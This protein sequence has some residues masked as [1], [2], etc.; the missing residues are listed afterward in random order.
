MVHLRLSA[1]PIYIYIYISS[2]LRQTPPP[3]LRSSAVV[4]PCSVVP[5]L[6]VRQEWWNKTAPKQHPEHP[7]NPNVVPQPL[8]REEWWNKTAPKQRPEGPWGALELFW[9]PF[10]ST[11]P[12]LREVVEHIWAC[13][14]EFVG[15]SWAA[16]GPVWGRPGSSSAVSGLPWSRLRPVLGR[17]GAVLRPLEGPRRPPGRSLEATWGAFVAS[18]ALRGPQA[19]NIE[20]PMV[21]QCF[22]P[23]WRFQESLLGA[24]WVL[25]GASR[26]FLDASGGILVG[27]WASQ[28]LSWGRLGASWSRL[29]P[30]KM[31]S[32]NHCSTTAVLKGLVEPLRAA[33][34]QNVGARFGRDFLGLRAGRGWGRP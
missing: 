22:W 23:P 8:L 26:S 29:G 30:R 12:L 3:C 18:W 34:E 19:K 31:R 6:S 28:G 21:F 4:V 24:S 2:C 16:L 32:R 27:S 1:L 20:K 14:G 11:T 5:Q 25:L 7:L 9:G 15:P 33:R 17:L 10:C 13:L